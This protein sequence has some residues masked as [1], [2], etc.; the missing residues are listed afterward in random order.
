MSKLTKMIIVA[1]VLAVL[2]FIEDARLSSSSPDQAIQSYSHPQPWMQVKQNIVSAKHN[3]K[4]VYFYL[5][6]EDNI[7]CAQLTK[8]LF[9]W[10]VHAFS[11]GSGLNLKEDGIQ[12]V[13]GY[14]RSDSLIFGLAGQQVQRIEINRTAAALIPLEFYIQDD[15]AK[16]KQLWYAEINNKEAVHIQVYD[17]E[18]HKISE[19]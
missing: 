1:G 6:Q 17:K 7:V 10:K 3:N 4:A 9:G 18:N 12:S 19:I 5:N 13:N 11:T 14:N 15:A 8:S 16:G 2:Y